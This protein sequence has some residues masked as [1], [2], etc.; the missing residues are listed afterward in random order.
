MLT[1][2]LKIKYRYTVI[3][4]VIFHLKV[5]DVQNNSKMTYSYTFF[6]C[7]FLGHFAHLGSVLMSVDY[8]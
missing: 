3:L 8:Y 4:N 2:M 7:H 5:L 6:E 1:I